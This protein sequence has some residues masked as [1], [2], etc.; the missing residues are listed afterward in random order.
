MR[1]YVV[2]TLQHF[3]VVVE[4]SKRWQATRRIGDIV[5]WS[6]LRDNL[7]Q[8]ASS[9]SDDDE[10]VDDTYGKQTKTKE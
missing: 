8:G 7:W 4:M 1:R 9:H 6:E 2:T 3:N 10:D 5:N